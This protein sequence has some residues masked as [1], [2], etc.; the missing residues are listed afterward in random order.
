[1]R[2]SR[3]NQ[4]SNRQKDQNNAEKSFKGATFISAFIQRGIDIQTSKIKR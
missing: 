1:M 2:K 3:Y 4:K